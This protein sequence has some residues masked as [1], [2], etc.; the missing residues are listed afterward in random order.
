MNRAEIASRNRALNWASYGTRSLIALGMPEIRQIETTSVC[1]L[2]CV[3]CPYDEMTRAKHHMDVES[4][5][6]FLGRRELEHVDEIALHHFGEPF[7]QANFHEFVRTATNLGIGT[8]VSSN[9]TRLSEAM[10][11]RVLGAGLSRLIVSIDAA[12]PETYSKLRVRGRLEDVESN[13]RMLLRKKMEMGSSI[14]IQTQFIV[15]PENH[16]EVETFESRWLAE[17]G[18]DQVVIRHERTHAG[19]VVRHS[20]YQNREELRQPCRYLWESVVIMQD[21]TVVPCCKDFDAKAPL[22]NAFEQDLGEIWNGDVVQSMRRSH[23]DSNYGAFSLC[24][25]CSEW[26]GEPAFPADEAEERVRGFAR[27]KS[28]FRDEP[29]HMR[30]WE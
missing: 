8:V 4:F 22:G 13:L 14:F 20:Q 2:R 3:F 12:K 28:S 15:T 11:E 17:P 7:L 6:N 23:I 26:R 16:S 24:A 18:V 29:R 27:L 5:R 21:G 30:V 1:N 25:N 9:M 19:Q 10:V